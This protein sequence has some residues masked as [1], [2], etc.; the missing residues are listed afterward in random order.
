[1]V[2]NSMPSLFSFLSWVLVLAPFRDLESSQGSG[3]QKNLNSSWSK[4]P[5]GES[6]Q[7]LEEPPVLKEKCL[8]KKVYR[9]PGWCGSVDWTLACEPKGRQ[10][11]SQSGHMPGLWA[12][13][14][15]GGIWEAS[16][17]WC[18]SPSFFLPSLLSKSKYIKS[19]LKRCI[20]NLEI[21]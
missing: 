20:D 7:T 17:H 4:W 16:T 9:S 10:F 12:R 1:M 6:P 3:S 19:F 13:S 11:N 2:F 8:F 18:F 21:G 15:F 5:T 14:S